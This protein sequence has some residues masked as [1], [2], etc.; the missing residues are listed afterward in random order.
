MLVAVAWLHLC[1]AAL[2]LPLAFLLPELAEPLLWCAVLLNACLLA[3]RDYS[4]PAPPA[5]VWALYIT[6]DAPLMLLGWAFAKAKWRLHSLATAVAPQVLLGSLPFQCDVSALQHRG[7]THVVNMCGET[8]GPTAKYAGAGIT[9]LHVPVADGDQP[10]VDQ[11]TTAVTWMGDVLSAPATP[12]TPPPR[13]LVH[14]KAGMGRSATVVLCHFIA[15]GWSGK[16]AF[17]HMKSLRPEVAR[18]VLRYASVK[19]FAAKVG[20]DV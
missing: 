19:A 4:A 12:D 15:N 17:A 7:V 11:I 5:M 10:T 8:P 20:G 3:W 14:C 13:V 2:L 16:K 1:N 18:S 9:Q 6:W